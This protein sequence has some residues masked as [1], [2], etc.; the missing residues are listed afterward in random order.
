MKVIPLVNNPLE[1]IA[2][3]KNQERKAQSD[4]YQ[5]YAPKML[6]VC[7]RY[8]RD[9]HK[10]E[11]VMVGAFVKVFQQISSF[12]NK[13]SFEGW[14]RRIMVN[15]S[16]SFLRS[17]KAV[18]FIDDLPYL[19]VHSEEERYDTDFTLEEMEGFIDQL[20]IGVRTVFNLFVIEGHKHAEI[21]KMLGIQEG[22]SK[23]QLAHARKILQKQLLTKNKG[24]WRNGVK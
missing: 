23:S 21:A 15:E 22:T 14:I 9:T 4:V 7:R 13:G 16:L 3:L 2:L 8:I 1:L 5:L 17:E 12:E 20:P 11:H 6:S 10:A 19:E 18:F 24:T